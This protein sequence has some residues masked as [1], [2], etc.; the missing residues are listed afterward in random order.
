MAVLKRHSSMPAQKD[1]R[2]M[3]NSAQNLKIGDTV[4]TRATRRISDNTGPAT[5]VT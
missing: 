1:M 2:M 4:G 3:I 5:I